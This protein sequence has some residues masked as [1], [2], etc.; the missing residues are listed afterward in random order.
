MV[1]PLVLIACNRRSWEERVTPEELARLE[2]FARWHWLNVEAPLARGGLYGAAQEDGVAIA[3]LAAA[4][5]E[6]EALVI[7]HGSPPISAGLLE[8]APRLRL[9]GELEGDRFAARIDVAAAWARGI[10]VVDTTNASS[11]PVAEWAL[12]ML[13]IALRNAGEQ[14]RHLIGEEVYRRPSSD[15]GHQR[16]ELTGKRVG[17]IGCGIIGRRF[18]E[19]LKPFRCDVRVYDPY[20]AR[21]VADALGFLL[22]TLDYVLSQSDAVVCLAPLTPKTRGMLGAR[23]LALLPPGG[24]FVNVSR[25]AIVDSAALIDRLQRG[26]ITASL[27]VFDPEPIPA[28]S[29][30]R[31]LPNVFLTPHIAGVTAAGGPRSFRL[32]VDELERFF[33]GHEPLFELTPSVVAQRRGEA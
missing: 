10:R 30:I 12:A 22:T 11:Y 7:C 25:G 5:P 3:Q 1:K 15:L 31:H 19:L 14:F 18:L 16:G 4:L 27:D 6:A 8:A 23:E 32:M 33:H 20:L 26:D 29:P 2:D 24:A 9:V 21:E 17:L 13:L 28:D